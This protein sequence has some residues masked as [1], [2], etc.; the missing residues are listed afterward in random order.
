MPESLAQTVLTPLYL[1]LKVASFATIFALIT[2]VLSAYLI[3]RYKGRFVDLIDALLTLPMVMPPPVL[4]YYLLVFL[5][6]KSALGEFLQNNFGINLIFTWEG[7]VLAAGLVAFPL[8]YKAGRAALEDVELHFQD[9]GRI[10]GLSEWMVFLRITL[11]LAWRGILAGGMLAFARA[12]G[13]FGATLMVAGNLPG[14]TQTLS[15][16]VY[17]AV[18][19][20]KNDLANFLVIL[21]SVVCVLILV[22]SGRLIKPRYALNQ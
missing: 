14:K 21:I 6:R 8:V 3:S 4:G 19:A 15:V 9:A 18:Q 10:L 5:G 12:L 1:S 2:G 17:A 22:A 11:P 20:G 13:E 16:A 7:A